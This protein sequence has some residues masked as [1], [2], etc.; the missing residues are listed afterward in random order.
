MEKTR[1]RGVIT[2]WW[3]HLETGSRVGKKT[4]NDLKGWIRFIPK[5][6]NER[7][8]KRDVEAFCSRFGFIDV[9]YVYLNVSQ[10]FTQVLGSP[11][12][13]SE[14]MPCGTPPAL[15]NVGHS[16]APGVVD[17]DLGWFLNLCEK[18]WKFPK[19]LLLVLSA[20]DL[21]LILWS[22]KEHTSHIILQA[23]F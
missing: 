12:P 3:P 7:H 2:R 5:E 11:L 23:A 9:N 22:P 16:S 4:R 13:Y 21:S 6:E 8:G 1:G 17:Q 18:S 20:V 19:G 15:L 10:A 14:G